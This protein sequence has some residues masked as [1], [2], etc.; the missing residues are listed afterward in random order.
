VRAEERTPRRGETADW[1]AGARFAAAYCLVLL[2]IIEYVFISGLTRAS[3]DLCLVGCSRCGLMALKRPR[4]LSLISPGST[5]KRGS[6]MDC[7]HGH[8]R[9]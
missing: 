9:R 3:Y 4:T 1:P 6:A 7:G 2:L 8:R 5:A